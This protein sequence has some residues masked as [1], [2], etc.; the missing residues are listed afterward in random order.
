MI[1]IIVSVGRWGGFLFRAAAAQTM[2]M[3]IMEVKQINMRKNNVAFEWDFCSNPYEY[4]NCGCRLF[5]LFETVP[6]SA[7]CEG[8]IRRRLAP[9]RVDNLVASLQLQR[10]RERQRGR[11]KTVTVCSGALLWRRLCRHQVPMKDTVMSAQLFR[12]VNS[13]QIHPERSFRA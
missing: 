5:G 4:L 8:P 6:S 11:E 3:T 2:A 10:T 1:L 9:K 13:T 12:P 7:A